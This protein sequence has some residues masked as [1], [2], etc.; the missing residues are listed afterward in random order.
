MGKGRFASLLIVCTSLSAL[1]VAAEVIGMNQP[2]PPLDAARIATLPEA[3]QAA[4]RA[5]LQ[6]SET[7]READRAALAAE[8]PPGQPEPAPP[9]SFGAGPASMPMDKPDDWY[10]S[11]AARHIGDTVLSFQTP[12][13]GW[14]KNQNRAG[15][16]RL[17][18]QRFSSE[19]GAATQDA[20]NFDKSHDRGWAYVGTIDNGAT[21]SEIRF[22]AR[23]S[24]ALPSKAGDGYRKGAIKGVRYLLA[25]Q[26]PNGGWPQIWPLDGGYHDG[27]TFND[28][29]MSN[30]SSLLD[31]VAHDPAWRFVPAQ[32]RRQSATA[33]A[34]AL[35]TI[36]AAQVR[37]DGRRT[38]WPQQVDPL[39]LAPISARNYEP[40]SIASAETADILMFLMRQRSQT[41]EVR[42]AVDA[43]VAWLRSVAVTGYAWTGTP[44]GRK[45]IPQ[46]GGG[47]LWSRN[48]DPVSGKPIF[49]DRDRTI[50]DDVNTISAGRRN[51][52]AWWVTSPARAIALHA[53]WTASKQ[54]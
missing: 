11:A 22:L 17:P 21:T 52:Y 20:A 24:Q 51:G 54:S 44:E 31:E 14:S 19:A 33:V 50:H 39:T 27:I 53:E 10:A 38:G 34:A 37:Q 9:A 7:R 45:L 30:V 49:G 29:A 26:Y 16:A 23:L 46:A 25:A 2:A 35:R 8:L 47:P 3:Q 36:L 18:G 42:A 13:G 48:Y 32:L 43:G 4:W 6:R 15:P 12:A 41:A 5:Y 40:R 28:D 1:P